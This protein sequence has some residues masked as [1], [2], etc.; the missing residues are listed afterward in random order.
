[1][2]KRTFAT[3]Q[4]DGTSRR[5]VLKTATAAAIG[6]ILDPLAKATPTTTPIDYGQGSGQTHL[7]STNL[8]PLLAAWLLLTTNGPAETVDP[9]RIA[10]VANIS[11]AS[12]QGIWNQYHNNQ[13]SFS[14]V[15]G[16]FGTLAKAFATAAP[17]SG[18][19]CPEAAATI[20][21]VAA[22][23]CSKVPSR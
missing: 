12:A 13:A 22:L 4:N 15:R 8:F 23:P 2:K 7:D 6:L 1:M 21:P 18:G 20:A 5:T 14:K 17:Y 10:S 9:A 19:Q 16:A 3:G 11:A